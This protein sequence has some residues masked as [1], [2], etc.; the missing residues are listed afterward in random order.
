VGLVE[1]VAHHVPEEGLYLPD[2]VFP[3]ALQHQ[4]TLSRT[5]AARFSLLLSIP[6]IIAAG[7]LGAIDL[8]QS[9]DATLQADAVYAAILAFAAALLAIWAM[10]AWL[11]RFS[12]TPF[13]V[14]RLVLG[15]LLLLWFL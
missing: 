6:T 11:K 13:V 2:E 9:G 3:P 14:Y 7:L 8:W 1:V 15:A 5:E 12:F 4:N 10:M